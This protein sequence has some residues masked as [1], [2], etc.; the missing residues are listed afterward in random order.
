[1]AIF[2]ATQLKNTLLW[3][4]TAIE[5]WQDHLSLLSEEMKDPM[6]MILLSLKINFIIIKTK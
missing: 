5:K 3:H 4:I 2:I 1:M 6:Q